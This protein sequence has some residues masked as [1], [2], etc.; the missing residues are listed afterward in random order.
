MQIW[1]FGENGT[2]EKKRLATLSSC[3]TKQPFAE[4][5]L[6]QFESVTKFGEQWIVFSKKEEAEI[7]AFAKRF[8]SARGDRGVVLLNA[9]LSPLKQLRTNTLF[10]T[11]VPEN[12]SESI[13]KACAS[14]KIKLA[15]RL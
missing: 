5:I 13:A 10:A 4:F 1:K 8:I 12:V 3:C 7:N 14:G 11:Y 9:L 6:A 2:W 15:I